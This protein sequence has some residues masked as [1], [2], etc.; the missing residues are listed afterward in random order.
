M[1]LWVGPWR[2]V[3]GFRRWGLGGW[4]FLFSCI[5]WSLASLTQMIW[6]IL[7]L[8]QSVMHP[9]AISHR[10]WK[11]HTKFLISLICKCD[12]PLF[13][14]PRHCL[15]PNAA[16]WAALWREREREREREK[17]LDCVY[18]GTLTREKARSV[19]MAALWW[20]RKREGQICVV[21]FVIESCC[22]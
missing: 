8:F 12:Q 7:I 5:S 3:A 14:K 11:F 13:V 2:R 10:L 1:G 19:Y 6:D 16:I 4:F 21:C 17:G 15:L 18:G 22:K 9:Y 20:G